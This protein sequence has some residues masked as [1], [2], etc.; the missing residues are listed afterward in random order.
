M[1]KEKK[2]EQTTPQKYH[3]AIVR[4]EATK[5]N[6]ETKTPPSQEP[7]DHRVQAARATF[8]Q[9]L[10]HCPKASNDTAML[11]IES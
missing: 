6:A 4:Q 3:T 7:R 2:T 5:V 10:G 9:I 11:Q 1:A 8:S